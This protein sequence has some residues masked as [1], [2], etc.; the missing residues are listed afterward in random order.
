MVNQFIFKSRWIA[1]AFAAMMLFSTYMLVGNEDDAGTLGAVA[2]VP[3]QP[4]F[5]PLTVPEPVSEDVPQVVTDEM[6]DD[7][8]FVDDGELIDEATG[9]DPSSGDSDGGFSEESSS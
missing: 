6:V 7:M 3:D 9:E 1:A 4:D 2:V 8:E 5:V